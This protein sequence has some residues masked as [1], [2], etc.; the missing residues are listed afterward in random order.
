MGLLEA[1]EPRLTESKTF[2]ILLSA[3]RAMACHHL[4]A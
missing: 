1:G 4:E 2:N 3:G